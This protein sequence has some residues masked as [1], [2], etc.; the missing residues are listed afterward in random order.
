MARGAVCGVVVAIVLAASSAR[1]DPW[2]SGHRGKVRLA[3]IALTTT[4]GVVW[5]TAPRWEDS[6]VPDTCRWCKPG[7]TD[8]AI[9]DALVWD[10]TDRAD[11]YS[12]LL[13]YG[14]APVIGGALVYL[15]T[16]GATAGRVIDDTISIAEAVVVTGV[17]VSGLKVASARKRP[18][19]YRSSVDYSDDISARTSFP[20]GHASFGFALTT[21]AAMVCHWRKFPTEPYVWVAGIGLS[22]SVEYLRIAAD[23]HWFSDVAIGGGIG[24]GVGLLVPTLLREHAISIAPVQNGASVV[25]MF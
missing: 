11:L 5:I 6:L 18:Y 22:L 4:L 7:A 23:K 21:S 2:Y 9:R 15:N 13:A 3:H 12:T 8:R 24:F 17:L 25:G 16:R 10:D 1:A 14:A 19:A 20:S